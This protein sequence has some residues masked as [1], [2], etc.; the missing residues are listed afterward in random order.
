MGGKIEQLN[1][2]LID[3]RPE[4]QEN[5]TEVEKSTICWSKV[6]H[7]VRPGAPQEPQDK[8][9]WALGAP[10]WGAKTIKNNLRGAQNHT[11]AGLA[12]KVAL[13]SEN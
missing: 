12:P 13:R 5:N 3:R 4:I 11:L 8:Q 9:K 7:V 2:T 10:R 1:H 6:G